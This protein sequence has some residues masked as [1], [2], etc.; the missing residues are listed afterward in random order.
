MPEWLERQLPDGRFMTVYPL[1]FGRGRVIIGDK[2]SV[3]DVWGFPSLGA[4]VAA[5]LTWDGKGEPEGWDRHPCTNRYRP[6]GD[7]AKEYV[8]NGPHRH[9]SSLGQRHGKGQG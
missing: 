7:P 4:A 1:T 6:G 3:D 9:H 8:N 5:F 2:A